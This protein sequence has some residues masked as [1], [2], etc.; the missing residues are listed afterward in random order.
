MDRRRV[1]KQEKQTKTGR[2]VYPSICTADPVQVETNVLFI[3]IKDQLIQ[4]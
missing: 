3:A 1:H 4:H 2:G